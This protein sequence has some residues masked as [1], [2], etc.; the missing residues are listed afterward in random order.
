MAGNSTPAAKAGAS[1]RRRRRETGSKE[2]LERRKVKSRPAD[3]RGIN[4]PGAGIVTQPHH[5]VKQPEARYAATGLD[6]TTHQNDS[7]ISCY[8]TPCYD[9]IREAP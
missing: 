7:D 2:S 4:Q 3:L 5:D 1:R 9:A 8:A 6:N